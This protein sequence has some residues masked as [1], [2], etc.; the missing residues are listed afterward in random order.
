MS[1][2]TMEKHVARIT[3]RLMVID[4]QHDDVEEEKCD[5]TNDRRVVGRRWIKI[6]TINDNKYVM[7]WPGRRC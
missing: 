4:N 7:P 5:V 6:T 2:E 3:D 1:G